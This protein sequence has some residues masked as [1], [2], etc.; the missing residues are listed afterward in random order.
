MNLSYVVWWLTHG[1]KLAVVSFFQPEHFTPQPYK[2]CTASPAVSTDLQI[3]QDA[4]AFLSRQRYATAIDT[5]SS[6]IL[7]WQSLPPVDKAD[8][9]TLADKKTR[10]E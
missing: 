1:K 9:R 2:H 3:S 10:R 4:F 6:L 7:W 8:T 5:L